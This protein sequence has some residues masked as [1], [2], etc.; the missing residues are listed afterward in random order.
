MC[1]ISVTSTFRSPC[2]Q[3]VYGG[4]WVIVPL[5]ACF[6]GF[7]TRSCCC[8]S[9]N[10]PKYNAVSSGKG[11]DGGVGGKLKVILLR[12]NASIDIKSNIYINFL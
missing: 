7:D 11:V 5:K 12:R 3:Y 4:L 6:V 2:I 10:Q 9:E 8:A 1:V